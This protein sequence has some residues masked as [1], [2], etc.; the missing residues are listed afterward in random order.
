[1]RGLEFAL[2]VAADALDQPDTTSQ[3]ERVASEKHFL[4]VVDKA[5]DKVK[6]E[7]FV[8]WKVGICVKALTI[9]DDTLIKN[10]AIGVLCLMRSRLS[11]YRV[12]QRR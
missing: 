12:K 10:K 7:S 4:T 8:K 9:T 2:N 1:M 11:A 3:V 6:W 5:I